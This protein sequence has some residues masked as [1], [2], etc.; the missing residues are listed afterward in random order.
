MHLH[1]AELQNPGPFLLSRIPA[2]HHNFRMS[3][4][5]KI[6]RDVQSFALNASLAL[7][8]AMIV[9]KAKDGTRR[10]IKDLSF[11]AFNA[12]VAVLQASPTAVWFEDSTGAVRSISS[13][14]DVPG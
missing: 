7:N 11:H 12:F 14:L 8:S 1:R 5:T 9:L 3:T 10:E 2:T 4:T 6:R 13:G